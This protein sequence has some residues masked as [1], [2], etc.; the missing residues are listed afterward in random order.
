MFCLRKTPFG[1]QEDPIQHMVELLSIEAANEGV[2]LSDKDKEVL[3]SEVIPGA[4]ISAELQNKAKKLIE[5]ILKREQA[6]GRDEDPKNFGNSL[7]WAGDPDY[8]NIV[9]L[10][11]E[12]ISSG[13]S[14][15]GLPPLH[16]WRR[17]KDRFQLLGCGLS[18]VLALFLLVLI[19]SF[20]F[21]ST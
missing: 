19:V 20:V 13:A 18:L 14:L 11:E 4:P 21:K 2:P 10:T 3:A 15:R 9:M 16:G 5:E 17:V 6:R 12:V 8:P 1:R 7:E